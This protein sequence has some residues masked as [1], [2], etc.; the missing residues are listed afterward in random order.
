MI[1]INPNHTS[2]HSNLGNVL[3]ELGEH[4]KAMSCYQK[5]I[6]INPNYVDAYYNL[7]NILKKLGE[8]K[9]AISCYQKAIQINPNYAKRIIILEQYLM[10]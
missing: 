5:A 6:K 8:Y 2:A 9:K 4:K 7:G 10:N 3:K 1:Q